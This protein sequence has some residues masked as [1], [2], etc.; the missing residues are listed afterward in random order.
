[1]YA[2]AIVKDGACSD[3][4]WLGFG[5]QLAPKGFFGAKVF[6]PNTLS[7]RG[8]QV[9][10]CTKQLKYE[11]M[12]HEVEMALVLVTPLV[13][14]GSGGMSGCATIFFVKSWRICSLWKKIE[15]LLLLM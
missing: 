14:S 13:F 8:S 6:N 5:I 11:Q 9:L 15:L 7:Y 2:T 4:L 10:L 3:I 1:M 12:I